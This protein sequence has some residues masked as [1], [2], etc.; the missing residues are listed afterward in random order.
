[1]SIDQQKEA[2]EGRQRQL[3]DDVG[4]VR[5]QAQDRPGRPRPYTLHPTTGLGLERFWTANQRLDRRPRADVVEEGVQ[6]DPPSARP[7]PMA[8]PC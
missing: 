7:C 4:Q 2:G 8:M 1:M 5:R 6:G 3:Q